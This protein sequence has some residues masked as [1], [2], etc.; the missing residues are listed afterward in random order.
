MK[1]ERVQEEDPSPRQ[2]L[3]HQLQFDSFDQAARFVGRLGDL[4]D[5]GQN[6]EVDLRNRSVTVRVGS[7]ASELTPRE[8]A[9]MARLRGMA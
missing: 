2:L 6:L 8:T 9:F 7:P 4:A 5:E 1:P 3:S